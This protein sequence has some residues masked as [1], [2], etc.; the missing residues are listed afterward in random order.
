VYLLSRSV[1]CQ[2]LLLLLL[3]AAANDGQ[4]FILGHDEVLLAIEL[5]FLIGGSQL[6]DRRKTV[7]EQR[8]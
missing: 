7:Q 6:S 5:D 1:Q 8:R 4:H 3:P 2:W